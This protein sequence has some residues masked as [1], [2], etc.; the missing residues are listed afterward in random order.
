MH[1]LIR[2]SLAFSV[3]VSHRLLAQWPIST[4]GRDQAGTNHP[5][6]FC[7]SRNRK[8]SAPS[9]QAFLYFVLSMDTGKYCK[10]LPWRNPEACPFAP[11]AY[12]YGFIVKSTTGDRRFRHPICQSRPQMHVRGFAEQLISKVV[13]PVL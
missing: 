2:G 8:A 6:S 1:E 12:L 5:R 11:K 3:R 4:S 7:D 10:G 13:Q 9:F